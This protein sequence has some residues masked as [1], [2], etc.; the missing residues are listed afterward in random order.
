[1]TIQADYEGD[2]EGQGRDIG[3]G[4]QHTADWERDMRVREGRDMGQ[5]KGEHTS[6]F[7]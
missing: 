6:R 7:V 1:M 5:G 3:Q 4:E 2:G